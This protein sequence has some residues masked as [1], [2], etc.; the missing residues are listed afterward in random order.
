MD[1]KSELKLRVDEINE[2]LLRYLPEKE[3]LHKTIL[4][5][6]H[7]SVFAGGKRIRPMLMNETYR[8]LGGRDK[9]IEPFMVAM[10][11]IQTYSLVHDDLPALDNDEYRRGKKSTHAMF[12]E[13]MGILAGD[14]LLN[15]AFEM[16]AKAFDIEVSDRTARAMQVLAKKAGICGMIGGQVVDVESEGKDIPYET[17]LYIHQNKCGALIEASMMMG[18]ILAGAD[19]EKVKMAEQIGADVGLA[20]QIRDD[21]LDVISTSEVLGKPVGS[22]DKNDKITY[23]TFMGLEASK[24]E[25]ERLSQRALDTLKSLGGE[26][27]FLSLLIDSMVAREF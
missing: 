10:E 21:V 1:F 27:E 9:V 20:F 26:N 22:D 6:M 11:M 15:Y 3:G 24:K 5:A 16:A 19:D 4:E 18:A 14:A 12:G 8:L 17:L 7:Y 2:C 23:V 25:V 13:A